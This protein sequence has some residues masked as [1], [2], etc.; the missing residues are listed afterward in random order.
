[1][2]ILYWSCIFT[3]IPSS[4]I[5]RWGR[6][7]CLHA[8]VLGEQVGRLQ[9]QVRPWLPAV[10]HQSGI[11]WNVSGTST[12]YLMHSISCMGYCMLTYSIGLLCRSLQYISRDSREEFYTI[13]AHPDNLLKK[14]RMCMIG[15]IYMCTVRMLM[16]EWVIHDGQVIGITVCLS[17]WALIG[18]TCTL[19]GVLL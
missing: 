9:R 7:P 16:S 6:R 17:G 18:G 15:N 19:H 3:F 11:R 13:T 2:H 5:H 14:V 1:M 8:S 10:W 4:C 12:F